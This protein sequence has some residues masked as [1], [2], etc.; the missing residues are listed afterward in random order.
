[1]YRSKLPDG[2]ETQI[3]QAFL[4]G[5]TQTEVVSKFGVDAGTCR[6][7]RKRN[8]LE[9]LFNQNNAKRQKNQ[10]NTGHFKKGAVPHNKLPESIEPLAIKLLLEGKGPT[11]V[12]REL[13]ISTPSVKNFRARANIE[14]QIKK[15][16]DSRKCKLCGDSLKGRKRGTILCHTC[17]LVRTSKGKYIRKERDCK[18]CGEKIKARYNQYCSKDC[19]TKA[20]YQRAKIRKGIEKSWIKDASE[21]K[22]KYHISRNCKSCGVEFETSKRHGRTAKVY[23]SDCVGSSGQKNLSNRYVRHYLSRLTKADGVPQVPVDYWDNDLV[24]AKRA[25]LKLH[26][27]LANND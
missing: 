2:L 12:A 14:S 15:F 27:L 19:Q 4:N 3:V 17:S 1:M 6:K 13:N 24:E 7:I 20:A 11:D 16:L 9:K 18:E 23:C 25:Q 10:R 5:E 26:R 22:E 8:D 21:F